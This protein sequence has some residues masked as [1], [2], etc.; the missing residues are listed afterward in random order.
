MA[1]KKYRFALITRFKKFAKSKGIND[2]INIYVEQ[3]ASDALID[4]YGL[5]NCY[6]MVEYYCRVSEAPS[7]RWFTYN[8]DKVYKNLTARKEDDRIRQVLR[9]QAKDW[10]NK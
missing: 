5:E 4:S 6:E 2:N 3:W 9:E 1:E 8:A 7:W 10:L